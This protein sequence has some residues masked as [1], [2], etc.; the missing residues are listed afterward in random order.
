MTRK[1]L[2]APLW[3]AEELQQLRELAAAGA[4]ISAIAQKLKRTY[5][6]VL[7][8]AKSEDIAVTKISKGK[9]KKAGHA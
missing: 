9:R 5:G 8:K 7:M 4:S 3:T 6:A 2:R 1:S